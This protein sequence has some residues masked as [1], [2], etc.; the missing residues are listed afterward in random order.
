M[1]EHKLNQHNDHGKIK[2]TLTIQVITREEHAKTVKELLN[3]GA[4]KLTDDLEQYTK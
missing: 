2:T 4:I 3:S 1:I